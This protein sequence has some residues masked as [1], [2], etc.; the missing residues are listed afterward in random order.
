MLSRWQRQDGAERRIRALG[1]LHRID[2]HDHRGDRM[3][4]V[5]GAR[6]K[7]HRRSHCGSAGGRA[8]LNRFI[9]CGSA[10]RRCRARRCE[11]EGC[12]KKTAKRDH[13]GP[14]FRTKEESPINFLI[15]G[16]T[17]AADERHSSA[18]AAPLELFFKLGEQRLNGGCPQN[19]LNSGL[20]W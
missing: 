1:L 7:S 4:G 5:P 8:D 16:D 14:H 2:I 17:R 19:A 15:A 18:C 12:S 9:D 3:R 13:P 20:S 11:K 6:G 10:N